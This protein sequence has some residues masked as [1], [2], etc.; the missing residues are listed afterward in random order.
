VHRPS[1]FGGTVLGWEGTALL[2]RGR[3]GQDRV[4]NPGPGS[5][6]VDGRAVTL[7][8]PSPARAQPADRPPARTASGSVAVAAAPARVARGSR[9][10]GE[11]VHDAEL[12]ERVW[13][14]DRRVEGVVVE[15][16]DGADGLA[17]VVAARRPGPGRRL[18]VLLDHLVDGSK[19]ARLAAS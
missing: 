9:L 8:R 11:G 19:E 15:R 12:G 1:G 14:D 17:E 13:G 5:F 2:V 18:G 10:R 4:F 6:L 7:A 16:L 3:S